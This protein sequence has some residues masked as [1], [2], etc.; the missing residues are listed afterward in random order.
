VVKIADARGLQT[1]RRQAIDYFWSGTTVCN[2]RVHFFSERL[3]RFL[4]SSGFFLCINGYKKAILPKVCP[5]RPQTA[6][7]PQFHD[8]S[9]RIVSEHT[10][11]IFGSSHVKD[12]QYNS[13]PLGSG[14]AAGQAMAHVVS[15][16]NFSPPVDIVKDSLGGVNFVIAGP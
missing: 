8:L 14:V 10:V 9:R 5:T 4:G 15:F 1:L 7:L 2:E 3:H 13:R 12:V 11:C 6:I 16:I